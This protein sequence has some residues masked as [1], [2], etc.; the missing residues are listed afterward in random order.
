[1][2]KARS[3]GRITGFILLLFTMILIAL[4]YSCQKE[5]TKNIP[6]GQQRV[7]IRLS[8]DPVHF[9][10][11]YVDIRRVE[12][13]VVADSCRR[14]DSDNEEDDR[15]DS[16]YHDHDGDRDHEDFQCA[17]WDT[18]DI[19]AGIYN[20][21]DLSN[22]ADTILASGFTVAG[23]I[24]KIRLTLGTQNSVVID[25]I[26]YPLHLWN[27]NN[28]VTISVRGEDIDQVS[29]GDFQIWLDFDAGQSIVRLFNNHF[30]LKPLLR[31]WLPPQTASIR[32]KVLPRS[33]D[34]VVSAIAGGDTLI[35]FPDDDDGHFK[36][37]GLRG[38]TADLFINATSG[39]YQDTTITGLTLQRGMETDV[40]TIHLHQ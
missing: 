20:L 37:R 40:G 4:F 31:I 18:L 34:A 6:A 10:A 23:R 29:P 14:G 25:S 22:G 35:A 38:A 12:V 17:V 24:K 30:V 2:K 27:N 21:L 26:S 8:D 7:Q 9:D 39:G 1:M 16:C 5:I 15:D 33:A 36:I 13:L 11:V 28:R 19:R 3:A 32:G